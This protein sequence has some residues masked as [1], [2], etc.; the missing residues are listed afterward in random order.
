M[1][2]SLL[3]YRKGDHS[4]RYHFR[5]APGHSVFIKTVHL[6]VQQTCPVVSRGGR[7][8]ERVVRRGVGREGEPWMQL[9]SALHRGGPSSCCTELSSSRF[10]PSRCTWC[11]HRVPIST[12]PQGCSSLVP[13]FCLFVLPSVS[14]EGRAETPWKSTAKPLRIDPGCARSKL[15]C[16]RG[17][18]KLSSVLSLNNRL[19]GLL[20]DPFCCALK[21]FCIQSCVVERDSNVKW[22]Y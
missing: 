18:S 1:I 22:L 13:P 17:V 9:V 15:R 8:S 19:I 16:V 11:A 6:N 3:S 5:A 2:I 12:Q 10:G 14:A 7:W 21:K 4:R 20:G